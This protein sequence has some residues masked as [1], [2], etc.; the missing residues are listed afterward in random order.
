MSYNPEEALYALL[1]A[2]SAA[3]SPE[4]PPAAWCEPHAI[5][6][7]T[8]RTLARHGAI[9]QELADAYLYRADALL[10]GELAG[11][12]AQPP[13]R[14]ALLEALEGYGDWMAV[15]DEVEGVE[16]IDLDEDELETWLRS[17]PTSA[18][19]RIGLRAE[20]I[21]AERE[22]AVA[23]RARREGRL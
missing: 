4:A 2:L 12:P 13:A 16:P 7:A 10:R 21:A 22:D 5:L 9:T 8:A 6:E 1:S 11:T 18:L 15:A 3:L 17:L 19:Q 14:G 23:L 20:L